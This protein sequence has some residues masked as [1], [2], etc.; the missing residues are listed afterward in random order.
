M[1][2]SRSLVFCA[3]ALIAPLSGCTCHSTGSTHV[4]VLT[5]KV[6]FGGIY[7]KPGVDP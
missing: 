4:G 5:R 6:T 7:G 3:A 1:R 2:A